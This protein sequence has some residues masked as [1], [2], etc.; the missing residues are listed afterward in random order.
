[1]KKVT[2]IYTTY[3]V[4]EGA[5]VIAEYSNVPA[6][7]GGTS[8]YLA[9]RLSTRMTTDSGGVFKGTQDHLPFGDEAGTSGTTEKHRFTTYERDA[10]SS[11]DYAMNRQH[12]SGTGR[13]MRPDPVAGTLVNPQSFNRYTYAL[14]DPVNLYD[15]LGLY[16]ACVHQAMTE[17]LAKLSGRFSDSVASQLGH[18]AGKEEGGADSSRYAATNPWNTFLGYVFHTG[19]MRDVHFASARQL[20]SEMSKFP[21]YIANR[22]FKSAGFVLHSIEDVHGAHLD[23]SPWGHAMAGHA[24]DRLI[25]DSKF[26]N[27]SN[28]VYQFLTGDPT[29]KLTPEQYKGLLN[30]IWATCGKQGDLNKLTRPRT[31]G[32]G[33]GGGFSGGFGGYPSWWYNMWDFLNWLYSIPVGG[34]RE[35]DPNHYA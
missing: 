5:Q 34:P 17:Y 29:G 28:E 14:N 26:I 32:G 3:Y 31:V 33:G 6:G 10:E 4:W 25:G 16:E 7:S 21:G 20:A 30:A 13:F 11:S 1:V 35:K 9:D 12:Q 27:V 23:L 22:D 18:F 19:P 8:Y 24:P 15:P 2:G